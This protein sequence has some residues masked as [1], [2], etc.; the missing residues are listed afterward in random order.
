MNETTKNET[1]KRI[2]R[3]LQL[4]RKTAGYSSAKAFAESI[5]FN[6][7]TYTQYEQGLAGF[8]YEQAWMMADALK[9]SMDELGG[10][11][12]PPGGK[13]AVYADPRQERM[14]DDYSVLSEP[15]KD[16]AAGAVHGIRLGEDEQKSPQAAPPPDPGRQDAGAA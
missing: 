4:R 16:S 2:G 1:R 11:E 15:G 13:A 7:N 10:R 12:W 6:P 5:G 14:N 3:Q 9:C 8:N